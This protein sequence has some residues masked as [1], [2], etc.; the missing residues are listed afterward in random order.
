[1]TGISRSSWPGSSQFLPL[2]GRAPVSN[3]PDQALVG[4]RGLQ[5][6]GKHT[7]NFMHSDRDNSYAGIPQNMST[8][9]A[10]PAHNNKH[11]LGFGPTTAR[12]PAPT[13][14]VSQDEHSHPTQQHSHYH[15]T[16]ALYRPGAPPLRA[17]S[18]TSKPG[19]PPRARTG[20]A[21]ATSA[22]RALWRRFTAKYSTLADGTALIQTLTPP[23]TETTRPRVRGIGPAWQYLQGFGTS[24]G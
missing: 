2:M 22:I 13:A 23:T 1:M 9:T 10:V 18:R 24:Q 19:P 21:S 12:P 6:L 7:R 4:L 20:S 11:S 8:K 17:D 16:T 15:V 3:R 5:A 14:E